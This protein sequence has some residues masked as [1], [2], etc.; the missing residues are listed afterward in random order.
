[1]A[2]FQPVSNHLTNRDLHEITQ[3]LQSMDEETNQ[4]NALI[5][6]LYNELRQI[7]ASKLASEHPGQTLQP[8]ALVH[9][10]YLRMMNPNANWE[11]RRHFFGAAA[12][13]MRRILI[14]N[15]R[16]KLAEKRGKNPQR[17]DGILEKL[18]VSD[19][20]FDLLDMNEAIVALEELNPEA[21]ELVKLRY[22]AG[23]TMKQVANAMEI[24]LRT[25]FEKWAFARAWLYRRLS[26]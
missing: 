11:S 7:A 21:A 5:P 17:I 9:E 3:M 14:E 6:M 20:S 10:T 19:N 24:S 4:T 1:M 18:S 13:A 2:R 22:F 16:R 26:S 15:A 8:T 23:L 12:E 25:A